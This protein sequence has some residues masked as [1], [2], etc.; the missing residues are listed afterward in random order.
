[1]AFVYAIRH[2]V[3]QYTLLVFEKGSD[4]V[5]FDTEALQ[6]SNALKCLF[7]PGLYFHKIK[8]LFLRGELFICYLVGTKTQ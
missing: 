4:N 7:S 8:G 1:M 5:F 3:M 6:T 2:Y